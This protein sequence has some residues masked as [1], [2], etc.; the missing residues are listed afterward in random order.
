[1]TAALCREV[2]VDLLPAAAEGD[3]DLFGES[4]YRY[5]HQAGLLFAP[6]QG[7]PM[8]PGWRPTSWPGCAIAG[9]RGVGQSSWG[10][11]IFALARDAGQA[12][13]FVADVGGHFAAANL[14][15]IVAAPA[16]RGTTVEI[17]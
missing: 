9:V 4:L 6:W 14:D 15:A 5:G 3:F 11:T 13:K 8:R 17:E 2:L 7:E 10:P 1:M 12:E 16:N